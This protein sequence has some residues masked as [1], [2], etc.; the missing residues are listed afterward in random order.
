LDSVTIRQARPEDA[1]ALADLL[2]QLGY[3]TDAAR[4][5]ERLENVHAR[6]GTVVLVA[7]HRGRPVG[8]VT[9]H[10]FAAMH[11]SY[12][13]AWLTA[14][15]VD[16]SARGKGVGSALVRHAEQWAIQQGARSLS[17]TSALRRKEAHEFYK[18]RDYQHTGVR[19][20]KIL[21]PDQTAS[22]SPSATE[23]SPT[24]QPN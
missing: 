1:Q 11:T 7:E 23:V 18:S 14:L 5:P 10:L 16:E 2:T 3:P 4:V 8:V 21:V 20:V 24:H 15:V 19:L 6:P 9:V 13:A 17:L 22:S 12:P